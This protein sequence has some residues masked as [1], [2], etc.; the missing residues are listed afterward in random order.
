MQIYVF[1]TDDKYTTYT[2]IGNQTY[3][4]INYTMTGELEYYKLDSGKDNDGFKK[5]IKISLIPKENDNI[6]IDCMIIKGE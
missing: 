6:E 1:L 4:Y 3:N 2:K 5:E